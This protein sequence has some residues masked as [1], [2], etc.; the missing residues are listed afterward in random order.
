MLKNVKVGIVLI[1]SLQLG[2]P[3]ALVLH[4]LNGDQQ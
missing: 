1:G 4:H 3:L 2:S